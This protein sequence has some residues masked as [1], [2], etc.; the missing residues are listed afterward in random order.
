MG[1]VEP[2]F[3]AE[4]DGWKL[5][6]AAKVVKARSGGLCEASV[7]AGVCTIYATRIHHAR[8]RLTHNPE[9]LLHLC[10]QCHVWIHAHPAVSYERGW[11]MQRT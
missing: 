10:D 8:G 5:P 11:M 1:Q 3:K 6:A 7:R 2:N 9:C 4:P